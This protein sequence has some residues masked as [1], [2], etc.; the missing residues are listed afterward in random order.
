MSSKTRSQSRNA[1]STF[2]P[3][4]AVLVADVGVVDGFAGLVE[5]FVDAGNRWQLLVFDV[6]EFDCGLGGREVDCGNR[7]D[8]LALEAHLVDG[9]DGGGPSYRSRS[10]SPC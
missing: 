7:R 9:N 6:D 3:L 4:E 1:A 8:G 10:A 5:R 2:T